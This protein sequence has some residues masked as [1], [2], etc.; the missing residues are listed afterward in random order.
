VDA[1][2]PHAVSEATIIE[3]AINV[4]ITLLFIFTSLLFNVKHKLS[5]LG[6]LL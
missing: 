4:L 6:M 1:A 5:V 2:L 3:T